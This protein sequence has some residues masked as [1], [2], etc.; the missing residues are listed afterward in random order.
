M[1]QHVYA[2]ILMLVQ[3]SFRYDA[4]RHIQPKPRFAQHPNQEQAP[5]FRSRW[6]IDLSRVRFPS[7]K[8]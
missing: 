4:K 5:T 8:A 7:L 3:A 1:Y 2:E 6:S